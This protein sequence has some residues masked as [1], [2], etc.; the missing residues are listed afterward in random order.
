MNEDRL[1][2]RLYFIR[3]TDRAVLF[4]L[5]QIGHAGSDVQFWIPRACIPVLVLQPLTSPFSWSECEVEIYES[6]ARKVPELEY[7]EEL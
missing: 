5:G 2:Y 7:A 1:A 3:Q 6:F 4:A